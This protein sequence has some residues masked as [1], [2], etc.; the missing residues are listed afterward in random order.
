MPIQQWR[1]PVALQAKSAAA[2]GTGIVVAFVFLA[3]A[4]G[5]P[6]MVVL[7]V[8]G[9]SMCVRRGTVL[10]DPDGDRIVVRYGLI[11]R[12]IR[13]SQIAAVQ[14]DRAKVTIGTADGDVI[15]FYAWQRS[16]LDRWLRGQVVASEVGHA[17]ARAATTVQEAA[18]GRGAT[19]ASAPQP[20]PPRPRQHQAMALLACAGAVEFGAAFG[21]RLSWSNPVMTAGAV[22]LVLGLGAAGALSI[23]VALWMLLRSR[24]PQRGASAA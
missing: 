18:A 23:V 12:R 13:L 21:V 6:V 7:G 5:I 3:P 16:R 8:W 11:T 10:L 20:V 24:W 22:I 19:T 17:I 14:V 1:C 15:S 9:L 4:L 2:A